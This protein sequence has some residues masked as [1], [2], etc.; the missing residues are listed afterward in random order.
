MIAEDLGYADEIIKK[1]V[2][3]IVLSRQD[4]QWRNLMLRLTLQ[5]SLQLRLDILRRKTE[6]CCCIKDFD[7]AN[8]EM[9]N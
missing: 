6:D 9:E 8:K 1:T 2:Q 7:V 3:K 5:K 4:G